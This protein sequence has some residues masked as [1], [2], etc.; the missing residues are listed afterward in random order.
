MKDLRASFSEKTPSIETPTKL[1]QLASATAT[2][3]TS[4]TGQ[5]LPSAP[6]PAPSVDE[7]PK[8]DD[9]PKLMIAWISATFVPKPKTIRFIRPASFTPQNPSPRLD[10]QGGNL[11]TPTL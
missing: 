9:F 3:A 4:A 11:T 2:S 5:E 6:A 7:K 1:N 10:A 8:E